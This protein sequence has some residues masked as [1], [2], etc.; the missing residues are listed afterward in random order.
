MTAIKI[1]L[2]ETQKGEVK[3]WVIYTDFQSSIQSIQY[4]KENHPI[5]NQIYDILV[6]LQKQKK[7]QIA[8]CKVPDHMEI[9]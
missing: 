8:L 2:K 3:R 6:D 9:K 4:N 7:K 1:A 5:L